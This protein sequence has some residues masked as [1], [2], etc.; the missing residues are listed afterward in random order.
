MKLHLI[1]SKKLEKLVF[2][3]VFKKYIE[4]REQEEG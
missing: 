1:D 2:S 4:N 3:S